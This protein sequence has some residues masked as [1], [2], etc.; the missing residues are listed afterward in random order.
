MPKAFVSLS[1]RPLLSYAVDR[2]RAVP[3]VA[4]LVVVAPAGF[5]SRD[6]PV[7]ADV[8]LPATET[9]IVVTGGAERGDSV[10][11]GLRALPPEIDLVL[12]HDCARALAPAALFERV[13]DAVRG[14]VAAVVPGLPVV[15]TIKVVDESGT[16]VA[17]PPRSDL[18]AVQTPQGFDRDALERAHAVHGSDATDDA[19]LV[20]LLGLPV[21][22]VPGDPLAFKVTDADDLARAER[23]VSTGIPSP[24]PTHSTATPSTP[25][26]STAKGR[27]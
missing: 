16:V 21:R 11:A 3:E 19:A 6:H 27:R 20:E 23:I 18:R 25:T 5:S 9:V 4:A 7:W 14:G 26:H 12:V 1:G 10:L 13:R 17:T 15:D 8:G 2:V 22:V 24:T